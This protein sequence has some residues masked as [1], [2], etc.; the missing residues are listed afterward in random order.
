MEKG[1]RRR[2]G[3]EI[4]K[5]HEGEKVNGSSMVSALSVNAKEVDN[6]LSRYREA[7]TIIKFIRF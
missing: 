3:G 2:G 6:N 7:E 1:E 4:S 5:K